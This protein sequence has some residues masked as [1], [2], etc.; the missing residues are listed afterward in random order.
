M[1]GEKEFDPA[2]YEPEMAAKLATM[3]KLCDLANAAKC[4]VSLDGMTASPHLERPS[5]QAPDPTKELV[6]ALRLFA[7]LRGAVAAFFDNLP[8]E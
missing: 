3:G 8:A 1:Y 5:F 7:K 4:S 2:K 6:G